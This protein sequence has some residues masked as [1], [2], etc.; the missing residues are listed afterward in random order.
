[1]T[2]PNFSASELPLGFWNPD[3]DRNCFATW[4]SD[5]RTI[6]IWNIATGQVVDAV[7]ANTHLACLTWHPDGTELACSFGDGLKAWRWDGQK[8]NEK[9]A[10][11]GHSNRAIWAMWSP[12]KDR[13]VTTGQDGNVKIWNA[14]NGQEVYNLAGHHGSMPSFWSSDGQRLMT[15]GTGLVP[16]MKHI[17]LWDASKGYEQESS[18]SDNES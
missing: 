2:L 13:I 5:D 18:L 16:S 3:P 9:F 8:L 4:S 15:S 11:T 10:V 7:N 1:M 14:D 6:R 17:Y 12:K